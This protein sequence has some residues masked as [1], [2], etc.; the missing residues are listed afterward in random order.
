M[1]CSNILSF[2]LRVG[3][4]L[5]NNFPRLNLRSLS[6]HN[7]WLLMAFLSY[8]KF[9]SLISYGLSHCLHSLA[10]SQRLERL[11]LNMWARK[12]S[13]LCWWIYTWAKE[14]IQIDLRWTFPLWKFWLTCFLPFSTAFLH[15]AAEDQ[16][17]RHNPFVPKPH[18]LVS[19]R[20]TVVLG[21]NVT[22]AQEVF[23]GKQP[24]CKIHRLLSLKRKA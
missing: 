23:N 18:E 12:A 10:F 1:Y 11:F 22:P 6:P 2:S 14:H 4:L 5:F 20:L 24:N 17:L 15:R 16:T 9:L 19:T 3:S 21:V 7:V 8:F 13:T